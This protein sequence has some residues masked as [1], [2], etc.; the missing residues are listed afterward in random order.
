M[1]IDIKATQF[2]F[3]PAVKAYVEDKIGG[4]QKFIDRWD[5]EGNVEVRVEVERITHHHHKGEVFRAEANMRLPGKVLRAEDTDV[6][7]YIS[8]DH[9]RE[10]LQGEIL[11]YKDI[12]LSREKK[13]GSAGVS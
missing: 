6:D 1:K 4:L 9:M 3:T 12:T 10:K 5:L 11:K 13:E 2:E 8:V 7:M